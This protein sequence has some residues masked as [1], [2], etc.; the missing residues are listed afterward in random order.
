MVD[1]LGAI[2]MSPSA[3]ALRVPGRAAGE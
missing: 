1:G 3:Q 2:A